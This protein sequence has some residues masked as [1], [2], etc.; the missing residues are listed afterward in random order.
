MLSLNVHLCNSKYI[1]LNISNVWLI[2]LLWLTW[3]VY[4]IAVD[5]EGIL[6]TII[7]L[8]TQSADKQ[9]CDKSLYLFKFLKKYCHLQ[10]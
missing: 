6:N 7:K 3:L 2:A 5:F 8:I 9:K 4:E 1:T 10:N